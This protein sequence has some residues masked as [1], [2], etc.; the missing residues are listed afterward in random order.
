MPIGGFLQKRR[1]VRHGESVLWRTAALQSALRAQKSDRRRL[2]I[3]LS[4][5]WHVA[6]L[7]SA[8]ERDIAEW[9]IRRGGRVILEGSRAPYSDML[10][11]PPGEIHITGID[12]VGT[13]INADELEQISTLTDLK[14]L[15][16]PGP[17]WNP[18]S[19]SR[20]DANA[21]LKFIAG[22]KNL[23][24]LSF[25]LPMQT[26]AVH[27]EASGIRAEIVNNSLQIH[28]DYIFPK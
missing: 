2:L 25:S 10:S 26:S 18:A 22:L 14:E 6:M 3:S 28:V 17:S 13:L 1:Q 15:H 11:L 7:A 4:G 23:E 16:L 9:A 21:Q 27:M 12:L 20:L 8:A 19:G 5:L 24:K